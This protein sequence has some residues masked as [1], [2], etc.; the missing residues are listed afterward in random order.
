MNKDYYVV[1]GVEKNANK[2][3]I[4]KAFRKLAHK[5]HPDKKD[6]DEAKFKE[7]NEAYQI[8][9][10][11][12]KRAEYDTYGQTFGGGGA[13]GQGFNGFS[14]FGG[15]D[16]SGAGVDFDLGDI[17]EQFFGGAGG[18]RGGVRRGNDISIGIEIP[19]AEA[20]F[21]TTRTVLV[22]KTSRCVSCDGSGAKKGTAMK[23]CTVCN[24]KGNVHESRRSPFGTFSV[25]RVCDACNGSGHVPEEVCPT[26]KGSGVVRNREE[27]HIVIP[28]GIEDG[29]MIR[30]AGKGEAIPRGNS[31]DLYVNVRVMADKTFSRQGNDLVM[32]LPIKLSEAL[33]G[34][35]RNV[36]TLDGEIDV[37]IPASIAFGETLRVRGKGVPSGGTR[38]DLLI[39]VTIEMPKK[40]SKKGKELVEALKEEGL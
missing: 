8:L 12:K 1:L 16:P 37:T 33:L 39:K 20:V 5:Y 31:G 25:S 24:G 28:E 23:I 38:G 2:D 30:M 26:C 3:D 36:I 27:I 32:R 10:D 13:G 4:K 18:A 6:G 19:F 34:I 40:L 9:S 7:V 29:A 21:G 17:F 15:F 11:D 14:G 22:T 35:H